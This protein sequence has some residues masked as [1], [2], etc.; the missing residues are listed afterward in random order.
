MQINKGSENIPD[1]VGADQL[2]QHLNRPDIVKKA[3]I[4]ASARAGRAL[5]AGHD[6]QARRSLRALDAA[7][8]NRRARCRG[9]QHGGRATL[10]I[11]IEPTRDPVKAIL[12]QVNGQQ[13]EEQT[14]ILLLAMLCQGGT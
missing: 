4:L 6:L 12:A 2:R 10:R 7:L 9:D 8:Q 1:Y 13:I 3:I 14:L 11:A 5:I